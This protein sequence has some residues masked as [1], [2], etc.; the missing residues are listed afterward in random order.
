[1]LTATASNNWQFINWNDG[2]TNNLR[3]V[4]APA[5]NITYTAN[6]AATATITVVASPNVGGSVT[7]G[8]TFLVGS[9]NL[10]TA[11]AS[12]GWAFVRWDDGAADHSH[13]IVVASNR[14]YTADFA[15]VA[16]VTVVINPT[17]AGVWVTGGGACLVGSNAVLTA[18]VPTPTNGNRWMF[19]NWN[20]TVT[21]YTKTGNTN[22]PLKFTVTSNITVTANF[23]QVTSDGFVYTYTWA[24]AKPTII[25]INKIAR[26]M[27]DTLNLGIEIIGYVGGA[28]SLIIPARIDGVSVVEIGPK[29]F[30]GKENL[31]FDEG[32]I[33]DNDSVFTCDPSCAGE[34]VADFSDFEGFGELLEAGEVVLEAGALA[35]CDEV[36]LPAAL[37]GAAL[38]ILAA[39]VSD[40]AI[41]SA[42]CD[43]ESGGHTSGSGLYIVGTSVHLTASANSGWRFNGWSDGTKTNRYW[44]TAPYFVTAT[45]VP[46]S[47]VTVVATPEDGGLVSGGGTYDVG[48]EIILTAT[49]N[50]YWKFME[51]SD[52][53][54]NAI[55]QIKV[56]AYDITYT[57]TFEELKLEVEVEAG[58]KIG[59][60]APGLTTG[61]GE[62]GLFDAV[63]L[64]ATPIIPKWKFNKWVLKVAGVPLDSH[65]FTNSS[66]VPSMLVF[67]VTPEMLGLKLTVDADFSTDVEVTT[68]AN[69]HYAGSVEG[70]G[71][72]EWPPVMDNLPHVTAIP[73]NGWAF[74]GWDSPITT[75]YPGNPFCPILD[76]VTPVDFTV[77]ANFTPTRLTTYVSGNSLTLDW[78]AGLVL[79]S[80][81]NTLAGTNWFDMPGTGASNSVVIPMDPANAAV[82]YRLRQP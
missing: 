41:V 9:T 58:P 19:L 4:T 11:V 51:W 72:C 71:S 50:L 54:T 8:G 33:S 36:L 74:T 60:L 73:A 16:T 43:P 62:Y 69:P 59:G 29:A 52:G 80:Q 82:F 77:T 6:F 23:A 18:V 81:T 22:N 64:T 27:N 14:T 79:Q 68:A 61:G 1:V 57:A 55:H 31:E 21:N 25:K 42:T 37:S 15:P 2:V 3:V 10:I 5:T 44:V 70:A 35:E 32:L 67:L 66:P 17:N 45:Y 24:R 78:P 65:L 53:D 28:T 46:V 20:G 26:P 7:G 56:P 39:A 75:N 48:S 30:T 38:A 34:G 49:N 76:M 63:T 40:L 47:T 13:A 12:N